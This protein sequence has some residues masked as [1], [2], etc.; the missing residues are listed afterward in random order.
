M[1]FQ[2]QQQQTALSH[3]RGGLMIHEPDYISKLGSSPQ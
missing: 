1:I 3:N 2:T